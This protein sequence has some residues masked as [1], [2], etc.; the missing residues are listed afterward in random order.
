MKA[1]LKEKPVSYDSRS[2]C[3]YIEDY[4][5][6]SKVHIKYI[7]KR[8]FGNFMRDGSRKILVVDSLGLNYLCK[9]YTIDKRPFS[10]FIPQKK[11]IR[12]IIAK[13]KAIRKRIAEAQLKSIERDRQR[14]LEI[15]SYEIKGKRIRYRKRYFGEKTC[16]SKNR[17]GNI[18]WKIDLWEYVIRIMNYKG[19]ISYFCGTKETKRDLLENCIFKKSD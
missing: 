9:F 8:E 2:G 11:A 7:L 12:N 17:V 18:T 6:I 10:E 1:Y 19:Y 15:Y 4:E 3:Y 13:S 14:I 16:S 5:E